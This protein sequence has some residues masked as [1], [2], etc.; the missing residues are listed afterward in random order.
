MS[1]KIIPPK[2]K[3]GKTVF[4]YGFDDYDIARRMS[5]DKSIVW[6]D[7]K[8]VNKGAA[9]VNLHIKSMMLNN[10]KVQI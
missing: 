9:I 3:P 5:K 4:Y 2:W 6:M 1:E 10:T 7:M 8:T